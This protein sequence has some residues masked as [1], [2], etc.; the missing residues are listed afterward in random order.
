MIDHHLFLEKWMP[1]IMMT[2]KNMIARMLNSINLFFLILFN[3]DFANFP[4]FPK[5][6]SIPL[7]FFLLLLNRPVWSTS[8]SPIL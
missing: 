8:S 1:R 5:S 2:T 3:I 4:L 6:S 7:N